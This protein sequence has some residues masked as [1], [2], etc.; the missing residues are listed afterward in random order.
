MPQ[1]TPIAGREDVV[2]V[3]VGD[4][5]GLDRDRD[6]GLGGDG[7]KAVRDDRADDRAAE[8]GRTAAE[9]QAGAPR[10][11]SGRIAG[12]GDL[13]DDRHVRSEPLRSD[14]RTAVRAG[15]LLSR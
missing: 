9:S 7:E 1:A 13:E 11:G 5:S 4:L 8:D 14:P 12:I 10:R 2:G 15:F 6:A 3:G